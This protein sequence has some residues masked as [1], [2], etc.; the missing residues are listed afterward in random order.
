MRLSLG[1]QCLI[2]LAA[3]RGVNASGLLLAGPCLDLRSLG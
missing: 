3:I 1:T 2:L